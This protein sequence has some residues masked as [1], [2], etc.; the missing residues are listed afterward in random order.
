MTQPAAQESATSDD[1]VLQSDAELPERQFGWWDMFVH[2]DEDPREQGGRFTGERATLVR[3]LRDYRLTLEMKCAGL[4]A[5]AM[6][7]RSVPPSNLSLLGLVRHLAGTEQAWFRIVLAGQDV[8]RLY[9]SETDPNGDFNGAVADPAVVAEAWDTWRSEVAFAEKFVDEAPDLDV[10]GHFDN[11]HDSGD[12]A[13]RS[14]M[15]HM[16]EEYARHMGHADFLRERIDGRV[17]Q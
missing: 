8:P 7:R 11:G 9:H 6:A 15:V 16:I 5:E 14:V 1:Q 10:C 13:L 12:M 17:G 3:Y 4:D 2:P